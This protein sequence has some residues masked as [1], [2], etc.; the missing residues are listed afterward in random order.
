MSEETSIEQTGGV[1]NV[2]T[3]IPDPTLGRDPVRIPFKFHGDGGEF[4]RIWIVNIVL[5]ILTLGIY[6]AWA[7]VRTK[8]YFYGNTELDGDRFDYL[9]DPVAILVGRILA[10]VLLVFFQALLGFAPPF[11]SGLI[12]LLFLAALPWVIYRA[13]RFNA[14]MSSWRGVRFGFDGGWAGAAKAY[15]LWPLFGVVTLGFGMPYAWFKQNQYLLSNYRFGASTSTST[16]EP[17]D[18][19]LV[20]LAVFGFASFGGL[21]LFGF[22]SSLGFNGMASDGEFNFDALFALGGLFAGA[23]YFVF[24]V[25]I[26]AVYEA[27]YFSTVYNNIEIS[28][29]YVGTSVSIVGLGRIVVGNA[30]L[31]LVTLGLY[32]PWARVRMTQY[33]QD[34]LWIDAVDLD[35]FVAKSSDGNDPLGE[36]IGEAFDIGIGL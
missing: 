25:M 35:S 7:K 3:P 21:V 24:Y 26:F 4:F 15:L 27:R 20:A 17:N 8:R 13:L 32:Y 30:V 10:I 19:Y 33:L 5:S 36:E 29:N 14:Q 31:M 11:F 9:G 34:N 23:L 28:G 22:T 2:S 16:T 6:S 12:G 1:S 18:F